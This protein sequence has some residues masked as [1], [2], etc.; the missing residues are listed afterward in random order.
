V[1]FGGK[2]VATFPPGPDGKPVKLTLKGPGT[3]EATRADDGSISISLSGTTEKTAVTISGAATLASVNVNGSLRSFTGKTADL[4]GDFTATGSVGKLLLRNATG[5]HTINVGPGGTLSLTLANTS[6]FSVN[7]GS[8]IRTLR[9]ASWT[10]TDGLAESLT[11]SAV[12]SMTVKGDLM[13]DLNVG[14]INRLTV[15]GMMNGSNLRAAGDVGTVRAAAM[16]DSLILAGVRGD[17]STMPTDASAFVTPATVKGVSVKL[18]TPGS[19][20]DTI[21][22]A[23]NLGR[24]SLGAVATDNGGSPF[25][26]AGDT[27]ASVSAVA[28][29]GAK[30]SIRNVTE[31]TDSQTEGDF[32][33]RVL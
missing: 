33:L 11:A 13:A 5:A 10:D 27:I 30:F 9:A 21:I 14:T 20:S 25:G 1:P 15:G 3:G 16:R 18:K 8:P 7:S 24:L 26:V 4:V 31:P 22:A 28:G 23:T 19:F 2:T 32:V 17:V 29:G 12:T 6:D